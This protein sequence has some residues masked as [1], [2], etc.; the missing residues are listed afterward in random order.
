MK[1]LGFAVTGA[2]CGIVGIAIVP[3][4][5]YNLAGLFNVRDA[6]DGPKWETASV[7][8]GLTAVASLAFLAAYRL[9]RPAAMSATASSTD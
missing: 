9:L 5:L 8:L 3:S 6:A 7:V 4:F 2:L 1:R